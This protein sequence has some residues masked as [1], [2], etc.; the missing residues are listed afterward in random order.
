MD[1]DVIITYETLYEILR[2]EKTR[3]ELQK[4]DETFFKDVTNYLDEKNHIIESQAKK[5]SIFSDVELEKTKRQI[6]NIQ[7]IIKDLYEKREY[8]IL[9]LAFI[10]SKTTV[11]L[12]NLDSLL[13][14]EK[15][16]FKELIKVLNL[17]REN[18]LENLLKAKLPNKIERL[19]ESKPKDINTD[20]K[21]GDNK[22]IRIIEPLPKFMGTD[23][24]VYGPFEQE[25]LVNLPSEIA[26]LLIKRK[27]A[28]EILV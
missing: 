1:K 17:G 9:Q 14:E 16:I 27:K 21:A 25:S 22:L 19:V 3:Q 24:E 15:I 20:S 5:D 8:K 6:E 10:S 2:R 11:E 7:R 28:E 4:L 13:P 23:L 12:H 18:I 26:D